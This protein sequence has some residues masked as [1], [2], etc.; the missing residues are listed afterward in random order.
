VVDQPYAD[1]VQYSELADFCC[2]WLKRTQGHR[3]PEWFSTSLCEHDQ[4][5]V[6][7]VI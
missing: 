6:V 4:E 7:N 3:R 2:I 5:A 1:N